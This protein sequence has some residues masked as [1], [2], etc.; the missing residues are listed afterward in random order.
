MDHLMSVVKNEKYYDELQT[1]LSALQ[2]K[3]EQ[4]H[5]TDLIRFKDEISRVLESEI[6]FHYRLNKGQAET[7]LDVDPEIRQ[8]LQVVS[9][10]AAYQ[11]MLHPN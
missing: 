7:A 11:K 1:Q 6:A 9:D 10:A 4:N 3:I 5:T 2:S 8:A